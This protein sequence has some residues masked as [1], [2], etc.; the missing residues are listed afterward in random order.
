MITS[1]LD[2]S[3][4]FYS[5]LFF[6]INHYIHCKKNN[7]TFKLDDSNWLFKSVNGWTDYFKSIDF[8]GVNEEGE[9][10]QV[11]KHNQLAGNFLMWDYQDIIRNH[12]YLYNDEVARQVHDKTTELGLVH[13]E[14]DA[15]FIRR[16]DK[17]CC[18]S[19]FIDTDQYVELLLRKN[20][21]CSTIFVQTDDYNVFLDVEKYVKTHDLNIRVVTMCD[22]NTRGMVIFDKVLSVELDNVVI[23]GNQMNQQ[24][25]ETIY[26]DLR[27]FTPVEK[28]NSE[29]IYRHTLD[30]L[31][32]VDIVLH[33]KYCTL[34]NQSNVSRFISIAHNDYTKLFDVRYPNENINM[35]W[36]MCP[37][38]W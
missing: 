12:L 31:I 8:T 10:S 11:L 9:P 32:G 37:A 6:T 20:P 7:K 19:K 18:E 25:F 16:G 22:P 14:Y 4:G 38:Y 34:D 3:A 2:K 23:R 30:M 27:K 29:Q 13:G 28:M 21:N 36:S 35:G 1:V 24:Y 26:D 15:I 33:S 5:V 17:L